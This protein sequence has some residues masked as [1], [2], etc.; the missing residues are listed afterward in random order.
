MLLTA[1]THFDNK[2]K[3]SSIKPSN[4]TPFV[5]ALAS[6]VRLVAV[7]EA[8]WLRSKGSLRKH[9]NIRQARLLESLK[10][11][12]SNVLLPEVNG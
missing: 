5:K 11:V 8:S 10:A 3:T 6:T 1:K 7:F 2:I 4:I 9:V 12:Y